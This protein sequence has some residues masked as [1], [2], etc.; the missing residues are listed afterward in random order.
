MIMSG[1]GFLEPER[2]VKLF[3]LKSGDHVADFGAGHGYF[4]MALARSVG[5]EGKVW[6]IDIQKPVLDIIRSRAKTE[7]LLNIE[8]V[9]AD[10]E[11][12]GR[13]G[14]AERFMDFVV[15]GNILFQAGRRDIVLREAWRVLREGGRLAMIEWGQDLNP[16]ISRYGVGPP[17]E[18]RIKKEDGR[19]LAIQAGFEFDREFAAGPH[20]Y[21]LLFKKP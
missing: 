12:P 16:E 2:I 14:L 19:A 7:H 8:Y 18:L 11:E 21:G 20:H 4:T 5:N 1:G 9:W 17:R 10:L 15:I 3:G 13:S 6:A